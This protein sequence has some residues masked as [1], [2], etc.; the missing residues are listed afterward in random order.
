MV[1]E[2]KRFKFGPFDLDAGQ[3]PLLRDGNIVQLA[4]LR[5]EPLQPVTTSLTP[6]AGPHA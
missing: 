5:S 3:R 6:I 1:R 4:K 2:T